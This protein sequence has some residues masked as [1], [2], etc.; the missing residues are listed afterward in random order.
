MLVTQ[1]GWSSVEVPN[2]THRRGK[3][4]E[5]MRRRIER[6]RMRR[7]KRRRKRVEGKGKGGEGGSKQDRRKYNNTA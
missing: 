2:D 1:V 6:K 7:R 5:E 3:R 4:E